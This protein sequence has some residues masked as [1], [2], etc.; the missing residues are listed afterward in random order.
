M[1][2]LSRRYWCAA[3]LNVPLLFLN[4]FVVAFTAEIASSMVGAVEFQT[5]K[6]HSRRGPGLG[7]RP[8]RSGLGHQTC[9]HTLNLFYTLLF[10]VE[11]WAVAR[12]LAWIILGEQK[13]CFHQYVRMEVL[14]CC[15][16]Y[17]YLLPGEPNTYTHKTPLTRIRKSPFYCYDGKFPSAC[18]K[19]SCNIWIC[20]IWYDN[21]FI[22]VHRTVGRHGSQ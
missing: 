9:Q 11:T 21:I 16:W 19:L 1:V 18:T 17:L 5:T 22:F 14:H 20:N 13:R 2:I 7:T 15:N 10:P 8:L 6:Y 3:L 4:R 12:L